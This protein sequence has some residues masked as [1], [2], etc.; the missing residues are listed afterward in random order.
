MDRAKMAETCCSI[1]ILRK[2]SSESAEDL[3]ILG[4]P[5]QYLPGTKTS[6]VEATS[7]MWVKKQQETQK[8]EKTW[9]WSLVKKHR[10][11]LSGRDEGWRTVDI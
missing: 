8:T 5:T 4:A 2:M 6:R 11:Q 7:T 10:W 1:F 3:V 9:E